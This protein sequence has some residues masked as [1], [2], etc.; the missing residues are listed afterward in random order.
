M[1][2]C[3]QRLWINIQLLFIDY[4][5]CKL[6]RLNDIA[7]PNYGME[8]QGMAVYQDRYIIQGSDNTGKCGSIA[9]A[10]TK[11]H[12]IV[13]EYK[14]MTQNHVNNINCD[15]AT[16]RLYVSECRN[17]H[18]CYVLS[19]DQYF[20]LMSC[21]Q[22]IKYSGAH[23]GNCTHSF[24]WFIDKDYLYTFGGTG[25]KGEME[26]LKFKKPTK[27]IWPTLTDKDIIHSVIVQDCYVYQGTTVINGLLY[28]L[29]GLDTPDAPSQLKIIDLSTGVVLK[30]IPLKGIGEPEGIS[31][32]EDGVLIVNCAYNPTYTF[33]KIKH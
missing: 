1:V 10:D 14:F 24:D 4:S 9:V 33:I 7:V 3:F 32:C 2:N 28:A 12:R 20:N 23:Y 26:I 25:A 21:V 5:K 19:F 11:T 27:N 13:Y 22:K 30:T 31:Q 18:L 15:K 8:S 6:F 16:G 17:K 29:F